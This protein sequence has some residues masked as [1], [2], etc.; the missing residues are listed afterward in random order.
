MSEYELLEIIRDSVRQIVFLVTQIVAISFAMIVAVYYFLSE[1]GWVL[2]LVALLLYSLGV[3]MY[4]LLAIREGL[5]GLAASNE[6][7]ARPPESLSLATQ[8]LMTFQ[9]DPISLALNA[10]LNASIFVLWFVTTTF[11]LF[12]KRA[13]KAG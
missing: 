1:S 2:K 6:L 13:A 7:N 3:S 4:G 8:E 12:W 9:A 5:W 10:I 11:L